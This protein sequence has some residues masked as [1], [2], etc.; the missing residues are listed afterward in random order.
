MLAAAIFVVLVVIA[1]WWVIEVRQ[2]RPRRPGRRL[3]SWVGKR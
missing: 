1:V 2:N 3:K